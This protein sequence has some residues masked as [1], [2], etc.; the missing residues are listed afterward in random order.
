MQTEI[1]PEAVQK[2][3]SKGGVWANLDLK[4]AAARRIMD[5]APYPAII[6]LLKADFGVTVSRSQLYRLKKIL[7]AGSA[8]SAQAP[9]SQPVNAGREEETAAQ[10]ESADEAYERIYGKPRPAHCRC[11][12]QMVQERPAGL[13]EPESVDEVP[14][15]PT[16]SRQG[17]GLEDKSEKATP[18][19]PPCQG[20]MEPAIAVDQALDP[21]VIALNAENQ[22]L[23]SHFHGN[24]GGEPTGHV[25]PP[26]ISPD[27]AEKPLEDI[28]EGL[29]SLKLDECLPKDGRIRPYSKAKQLNNYK[30]KGH[31]QLLRKNLQILLSLPNM[32]DSIRELLTLDPVSRCAHKGVIIFTKLA[33]LERQV[34]GAKRYV[35][36][37]GNRA[38]LNDHYSRCEGCSNFLTDG[39][40]QWLTEAVNRLRE[41]RRMGAAA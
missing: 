33:C 20:G 26:V 30:H 3:S 16:L 11:T 6:V 34:F 25:K 9:E 12:L 5:G 13:V 4:I 35:K 37:E 31:P 24:D 8:L 14:P 15:H 10:T 7:E 23:D 1:R 18:P 27:G 38:R 21:P 39:E 40:Y 29:K 41:A 28:I 2:S 19:S 36:T 17:R 22:E 32:P